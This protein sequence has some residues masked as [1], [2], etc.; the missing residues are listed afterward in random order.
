MA[1]TLGFEG[2]MAWAEPMRDAG[3]GRPTHVVLK[4]T[5]YEGLKTS[6]RK[7]HGDMTDIV[8]QQ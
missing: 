7:W 5:T 8:D 4:Q 3:P 6:C 2:H 1:T